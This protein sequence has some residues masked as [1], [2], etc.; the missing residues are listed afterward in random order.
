MKRAVLLFL[1][2]GL[3]LCTELWAQG[4]ITKINNSKQ[5]IAKLTAD[6]GFDVDKMVLIISSRENRVVGFGR[7][8]I[9]FLQ[10]L[11]VMAKV[12]ITEIIGNSLVLVGDEIELL[13]FKTFKRREIPGFNSITIAGS[14]KIP[15]QYKELAY[16][17][18]F[19]SEGHT[20]DKSEVLIS[21]FQLQY[22]ISND[23]GVKIVNA[24][25]L[26]G[27][28]NVGFKYRAVRNKYAKVSLNTF[29]AYRVQSQD[30]IGQL[31][32]VLTMPQNAKFQQHYAANITFDPMFERARATRGL[33]LFQDSDIR[34]VTEYI[35]D[36]WNRVLF[37]PVYNVE[38]QTFGGTL[39]YLWIWDT[40]HMSLGIATKDFS[41]FNFG[42]KGYYYV[43]DFF[44]RF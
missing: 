30:W 29:G 20:L 27:Y 14:H 32:G 7:V 11:D 15:S 39:S 3:F 28:A 18:V 41:N 26:D 16:L 12:N 43:Y 31:G 42:T 37:G 21:P 34:S 2:S 25:F 10:D 23:F 38:L 40:F 6:A 33:G 22:G 13:D 1:L 44:W 24:L 17:G 4:V 19:S 36:S 35:T 8:D 9:F 5:V